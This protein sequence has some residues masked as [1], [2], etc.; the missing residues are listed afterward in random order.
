MYLGV[1]AY[2]ETMEDPR[3]ASRTTRIPDLY[4]DAAWLRR[5]ALMAALVAALAAAVEGALWRLTGDPDRLGVAGALA[6][7]AAW[8]VVV[9]WHIA[10]GRERR[11]V[12][13]ISAGAFGA[14]F[15]MLAV[16]PESGPILALAMQAPLFLAIPYL[17]ARALRRY[18]MGV[19]IAAMTLVL[20]AGIL[21]ASPGVDGVG[22]AQLT[23]DLLGT[24]AIMALAVLLLDRYH[25]GVSAL[26]RMALQD[27]L[28]GLYN[29]ALF[30]DRLERVMAGQALWGRTTAVIYLDLDDFKGINDRHGHAHGDRVLRAISER[31]S[32]GV[33]STDTVA[34]VGGDEFAVLL[35]DL[36]DRREAMT[37]ADGL[38]RM[39]SLPI[40]LPEG[41]EQVRASAGLAFAR[42]GGGTA[43]ALLD[44][45]D[46]ALYQAKGG[47]RGGVTVHTP[48]LTGEADDTDVRRGRLSPVRSGPLR[49][50]VSNP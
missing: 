2:A 36:D 39:V 11:G 19:W 3:L 6:A 24:G 33:R 30:V 45:A 34:R 4:H 5:V 48:G 7:L 29:R 20:V 16:I 38:V 25:H 18:A 15:L 40:A 10:E 32:Q 1:S 22:S 27:G 37:V 47:S 43:E 42:D 26:R 12:A 46:R 49:G 23:R 41:D 35:E 31:L 21:R 50:S 8:L 28:T 14:L 44:D 17:D 13:L 9:R